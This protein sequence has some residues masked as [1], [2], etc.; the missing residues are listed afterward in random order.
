MILD[1][2]IAI[3]ALAA[4]VTAVAVYAPRNDMSVLWAPVIGIPAGVVG[5]LGL[6]SAAF[7]RP[8]VAACRKAMAE[9]DG[10]PAAQGSADPAAAPRP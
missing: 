6:G 4:G 1:T 5:A 9:R 8:R 10:S 7:G 2:V 3:A